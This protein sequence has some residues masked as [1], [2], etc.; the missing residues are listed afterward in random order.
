MIKI[1]QVNKAISDIIYFGLL[2]KNKWQDRLASS[3]VGGEAGGGG[4]GHDGLRH[5]TGVLRLLLGLLLQTELFPP[6]LEGFGVLLYGPCSDWIAFAVLTKHTVLEEH[7]VF[8]PDSPGNLRDSLLL[9]T[10]PH[11]EGAAA[12]SG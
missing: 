7:S 9:V 4:D 1:N 2:F 10:G 8:N 3:L 5:V 12:L 11:P 6:N